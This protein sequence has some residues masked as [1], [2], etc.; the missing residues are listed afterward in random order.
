MTGI[1]LSLTQ[2]YNC[3]F[4]LDREHDVLLFFI[5]LMNIGLGANLPLD[6]VEGIVYLRGLAQHGVDDDPLEAEDGYRHSDQN[7]E[8]FFSSRNQVRGVGNVDVP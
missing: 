4:R 3:N 6:V 1:T 7:V 2:R 5:E 8:K